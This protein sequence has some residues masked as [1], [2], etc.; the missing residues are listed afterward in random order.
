M[1]CNSEIRDGAEYISANM[2][3]RIKTLIRKANNDLYNGPSYYDEEDNE[4]SCFDSKSTPFNFTSAVTEI[5]DWFNENVS[6]VTVL[7]AD[8]NE[9]EEQVE[10]EERIDGSSNEITKLIVGRELYAY[11]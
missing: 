5:S 7:C 1:S 9:D 10:W 3:D 11:L 2:P 6:D 4:T 8:L